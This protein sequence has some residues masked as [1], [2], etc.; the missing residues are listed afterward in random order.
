MSY[1]SRDYIDGCR[2][3]A[4]RLGIYRTCGAH[5]ISSFDS[6]TMSVNDIRLER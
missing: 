4:R 5:D 3:Q 6:K 2:L 1:A